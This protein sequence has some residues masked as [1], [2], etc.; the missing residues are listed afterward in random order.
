MTTALDK[1]SI[2]DPVL[3]NN[4]K[5][6]TDELDSVVEAHRNNQATIFGDHET[7]LDHLFELKDNF[8][9]LHGHLITKKHTLSENEIKSI[10]KKIF[11]SFNYINASAKDLGYGFKQVMYINARLQDALHRSKSCQQP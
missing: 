8:I 4:V 5:K 7:E 6:W 10:M 3:A 9:L 1:L 11:R 2:L